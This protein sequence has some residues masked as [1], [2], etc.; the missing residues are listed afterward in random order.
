VASKWN[1]SRRTGGGWGGYHR[2]SLGR[3]K[4]E[5]KGGSTKSWET[6]RYGSARG[7][8][9][10]ITELWE[11]W[12]NPVGEA[13]RAARDVIGGSGKGYSKR[14]GHFAEGGNTT[15]EEAEGQGTTKAVGSKREDNN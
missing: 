2:R 7:W 14:L 3:E 15:S 12:S 10:A 9:R 11:K 4:K 1:G 6:V 8:L 13:I 5:F